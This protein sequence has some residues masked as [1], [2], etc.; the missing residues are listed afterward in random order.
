[1]NKK[2]EDAKY[3]RELWLADAK[4]RGL[5]LAKARETVYVLADNCFINILYSETKEGIG[6][7]GITESYPIDIFV[8]L[9]G[10]NKLF[11]AIPNNEMN[12]LLSVTTNRRKDGNPL[13]KIDTKSNVYRGGGKIER[14]I[15][16]FKNNW[17]ILEDSQKICQ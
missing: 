6:W 8:F 16:T 17:K 10:N 12:K 11:Y 5:E 13:F 14:I 7:F 15:G 9:C 1:M 2:N 4:K 3:F